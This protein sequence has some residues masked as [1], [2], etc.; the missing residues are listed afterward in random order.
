MRH[1]SGLLVVGHGTQDE[2]GRR[3]FWITVRQVAEELPDCAVEGC[4]L[5]VAAPDMPDLPD[6]PTALDRLAQ[7]GL[8]DIVIVPL[9]L[10][11]AGHARRDIPAAVA[12]AAARTGMRVRQS[13]VLGC[14][15]QVLQL[16]AER[17]LAAVG[18]D[19]APE[20][21]LL[22]F[23]ARGS[24]DPAA[25]DQLQHFVT[26]RVA[27]TPVGR[28]VV[29]FL[30]MA[31]PRVEDVLAEITA[32][33]CARVVVQPHLLYPGSLLS[34]LR[35]I[36]AGHAPGRLP[37]APGRPRQHW[38]W[39]DCLGCDRAIARAV[40]GRFRETASRPSGPRG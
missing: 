27:R 13:D 11:S 17:F 37:P 21:V 34:R 20:S 3:D 26:Q 30:A 4:F 31:E 6:I 8:R 40:A 22:L 38:I 7:R 39:T 10:F 36:V 12:R 23:V 29:A 1:S 9:L 19:Y 24:R 28:V 15:P 2:R 32:T 25:T 35:R 14:H 5:E 16:S 18:A 33:E